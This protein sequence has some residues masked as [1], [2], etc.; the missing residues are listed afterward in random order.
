[1]FLCKPRSCCLL[2]ITLKYFTFIGSMLKCKF[3]Q[4]FCTPPLL[5]TLDFVFRTEDLRG[6]AFQHSPN[7]S[8]GWNTGHFWNFQMVGVCSVF[9]WCSVSNGL[10]H[11]KTNLL[12]SLAHFIL[13][14][15]ATGKRRTPRGLCRIL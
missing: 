9:Q 14:K 11:W 15:Q 13:R 2:V 5:Q 6:G 12:S 7:Y 8:G 4:F 3:V 10:D 1:M